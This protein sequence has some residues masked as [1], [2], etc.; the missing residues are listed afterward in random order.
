VHVIA[1]QSNR[2]HALFCSVCVV[3]VLVKRALCVL[4]PLYWCLRACEVKDPH[5]EDSHVCFPA[6]PLKRYLPGDIGRGPAAA[7]A[8]EDKE[9][10]NKYTNDHARLTPGVFLVHCPHGVCLGYR[11]M[12]RHEG[13]SMAFELLLSRLTK[14][15][16]LQLAMRRAVAAGRPQ[17]QCM[18]LP[19]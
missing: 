19:L 14:G 4:L 10:C 15:K 17:R 7:R 1:R 3:H 8:R 9:G 6:L 12:E 11:L 13:P 2:M 16:H 18:L 5:V